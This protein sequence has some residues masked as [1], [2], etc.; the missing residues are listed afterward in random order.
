MPRVLVSR[1][2][3][4]ILVRRR[5]NS[6]ALLDRLGRLPSASLVDLR[7]SSSLHGMVLANLS[8]GGLVREPLA[9]LFVL[10]VSLFMMK[11]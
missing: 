6:L 4:S 1:G 9:I 8:G 10:V 11:S 7:S 2:S 5:M 3:R